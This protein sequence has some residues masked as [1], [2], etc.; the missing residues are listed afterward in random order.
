M[1]LCAAAA[2]HATQEAPR[3]LGRVNDLAG[4][5]D[6]AE[7]AA[8]EARLAAFERETT[9]QVA[10]LTV[11]GLDGEPIES[12][13]L[14][15]AESWQLGHEG[16]DNGILLVVAPA[17]R[18]MRIEV[19]YGLEGVVPDAIAKRIIEDVIAPRFRAGDMAGGISEG[20]EAIL[21]AA[22]GEWV[23]PERRP[24]AGGRGGGGAE[25]FL[26]AVFFG[27]ILAGVLGQI[28]PRSL[29]LLGSGAAGGLAWLTLHSFLAAVLAAGGATLLGLFLAHA[30][31]APSGR[32]GGFGGRGWSGGGG[33]G[34][35]FSG[36]GGG[37]GGGGASGGW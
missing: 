20:V 2:V 32:G 25:I 24:G 36:G 26:F 9:H 8:L 33:F 27:G 28:G 35:G 14:R 34:G 6:D 17:E 1:L 19:G 30:R 5:L 29:S 21:A 3:L 31:F 13:A 22:Q 16:L 37:F 23:P 10:V 7:R 11:P 18:K 4:L 15:V 12:F